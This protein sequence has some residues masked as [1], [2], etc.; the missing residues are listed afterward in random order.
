MANDDPRSPVLPVVRAQATVR[1]SRPRRV[2]RTDASRGVA[3]VSGDREQTRRIVPPPP[4]VAPVFVDDT[5][6]RGRLLAWASVLAALIG[7]LLVV[8]FWVSQ[9]THSG[10]V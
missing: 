8:A 6:R 3:R 5:G 7:L 10:V 1:P 4:P 9:I 2:A